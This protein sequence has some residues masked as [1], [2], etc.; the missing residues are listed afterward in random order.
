MSRTSPDRSA[1]IHVIV[2]SLLCS[3]TRARRRRCGC[4]RRRAARPGRTERVGGDRDVALRVSVNRGPTL[5]PRRRKRAARRGPPVRPTAGSSACPRLAFPPP[6]MFSPGTLAR[7]GSRISSVGRCSACTEP[8]R[9]RDSDCSSSGE[10]CPSSGPSRADRARLRRAEH[11][12]LRNGSRVRRRREHASAVRLHP[13]RRYGPTGSRATTSWSCPTRSPGRPSRRRSARAHR[14]CKGVTLIA[15]QLVRRTATAFF[16]PAAQGIVPRPS[17]PGCS[18][19]RRA[20]SPLPQR[21]AD[22]RRGRRGIPRRLD[23]LGLVARLRRRHLLR[24]RRAPP[25]APDPRDLTCPTATSSASAGGLGRVP[26]A[27]WLWA[28]SSSSPSSTQRSSASRRCSGRSSPRTS[29]AE[30][31]HRAHRRGAGRR[32]RVRRRRHPRYRPSPDAPRRDGGDLPDRPADPAAA[33]PAAVVVIAAAAF[34]SES[35]WS[36]SACSRT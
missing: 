30:Q 32:V 4:P 6:G 5:D 16:F 28:S 34:V 8:A 35:G 24:R 33:R 14:R 25:R 19:R 12:S 11:R 26:L 20:A 1:S 31:P 36:S 3:L 21:D 10:R 17:A 27:A 2:L 7:D 13:R 23:R 22:L 9:R 29:S 15:L 18:R